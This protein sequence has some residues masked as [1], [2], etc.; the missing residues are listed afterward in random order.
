MDHVLG[1]KCVLCGAE[2][3]VNQVDYVCP[4]HGDEG[5]LDVVYD[6]RA[7]RQRVTPITLV[8]ERDPSIWRYRDLLP[9][10]QE[11]L[12]RLLAADSPLARVGGTPLYRADRL[13]RHLGL[14]H[15]YVKDDGRNPTASFK[16]RASAIAVVKAV[17]RRAQVVTTAS[18]GNAAAALSGMAASIGLPTVIFVPHTAPPA[19]VAQLLIFGSTVILVEGTYDQAFDLTLEAAREYGW[20]CRNTAYNPY[21]REGKKTAAFEICEQLG[22]QAPD[23]IFVSVG[24]GNIISGLHKG[25]KDLFTLGWI[26]QVPKLMGVQAA[27]SAV[28]VDAWRRPGEEFHFIER[29]ETIADSISVGVPRD[30]VKALRAVRETGGE[31]VVVSD[32]EILDAMRVLARQAAVFAE[33]A[34]AA[35]FAGL[36][37]L[38]RQGKIDPGERVVVVVTGNGLKDV[39]SAIQATGEPYRI[40]PRLEALKKVVSTE[41]TT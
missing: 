12:Q 28:L 20:Y 16:D 19:K 24:D 38:V 29:P 18:S 33:P 41:M 36:Q 9:V 27:G 32:E 30:R 37:K 13:A 11:V 4:K 26:E 14:K 6:Y 21:T 17:E 8:D 39:S 2:Y 10:D 40:E 15:L 31:Y 34:G 23:G 35:G 25:F 1:L 7:I 22:W 3:A 5:V